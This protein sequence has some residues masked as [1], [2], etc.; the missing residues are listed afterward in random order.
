MSKSLGRGPL[1][2]LR[3]RVDADIRELI[4][5]NKNLRRARYTWA[6]RFLRN[7]IVARPAAVLLS[8]YCLA[9]IAIVLAA[10]IV[11]R[12]APW[13]NCYVAGADIS[14]DATGFFLSAQIGILAVLSVA[15]SVVT[16][17]TQKDDGSAVNTDVR[18]YYLESYSYGLASSG[19][20]LCAVLVVQLFWPLQPLVVF[21][22]GSEAVDSVK[23]SITIV[24]AA[25]LVLNLYLFLHFMGT[26]FR[27]VEPESRATLRKQYTANEIIPR[28]VRRRL[29]AAY[30]LAIP[31]QMFGGGDL[32]K[33]PLI[34]LGT[35][36]VS[37][38]KG[39][40][41]I[42]RAFKTPSRL[43]DIWLLPLGPALRGW[44][45]RTRKQAP[46]NQFGEEHWR[47]HL[48]VPTDFKIIQE[49]KF[50]F[51]LREGGAPLTRLERALIGVSFR[52]ARADQRED[53]LPTPTEFIE[54][55]VSKVV[56]QIESGAPNGFDNA[57]SE[58]VDFHSFV[59]AAQN[60]RDENGDLINLAQI[61]DGPFRQ[62]DFEWIREYRRAYT[63]ATN[64]M[65]SDGGFANGMSGLVARLWPRDA[66]DFPPAVL[67]NILELGRIQVS[68]FEGWVTKRAVI[69][70]PEGG[71]APDLAGSDL[72]AYD[73]AL[74][75]FVSAWEMLEQLIVSSFEVR[76][77]GSGDDAT[78]WQSA[79]ASWPSL[80]M[81]MRNAAFFVAAAVWNEDLA[82]SDRFRDM[83]V[84]WVQVFYA[85]L[86]HVYPF[87]DALMLTPDVLQVLWPDA[88]TATVRTLHYPQPPASAKTVFGLILREAHLDAIAITG[89]VLLHWFATKQ[90]PSPATAQCAILTL[91]REAQQG[92]GS[93]LLD[94]GGTVKSVFRL[95][96]DLL[97]RE[98]LRSPF[99]EGSYSAYLDGLIRLLNEM[100][101]P[102]MIPGR[103]YGG[104]V[105]D[106]F[107]T[108]TPE[109]LAILAGNL[110][111][112]GDEGVLDLIQRLLNNHPEFQVDR[113]LRD[114]EFQFG[115]YAAALDGEPDARFAATVECFVEKPDLLALRSRLKMIFDAVRSG[116]SEFRLSRICEAPLDDGRLQVVREAVQTALLADQRP[117]GAFQSITVDRTDR[118]L[119]LR[120]T[121]WGVL[122]RGVFTQPQMSGLTF[123]EIPALFVETTA[124]WVRNIGWYELARRPKRIER[125]DP[126][127]SVTAFLDLVREIGEDVALG[128]E[129]MLLVPYNRIG[130]PI[131]MTT[132]GFP[133]DDLDS[134]GLIREPGA[135]SGLGCS[136]AGTLDGIQIYTWRLNE[137]AVLCSRTLIRA[138]Y[139]G[140]VRA[141]DGFFDF[142]LFDTGDPMQSRIRIWLGVEFEWEERDHVEFKFGNP[143]DELADAEGGDDLQSRAVS[144]PIA[145]A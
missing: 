113:T 63:A 8:A 103:I 114:F 36:L 108:L 69:A 89:A 50:D 1:Q 37:D 143:P 86:Q 22:A 80:Q 111:A 116:I 3:A 2:S 71:Q 140:D 115:R 40:S 28:D 112:T 79:G 83:L 24:H 38:D 7:W 19:I 141:R 84:R 46:Q 48:A 41:E 101:T 128:D 72:H 118:K 104:F 54:Q 78:Y 121:D 107:Q 117:V 138:L 57:L 17:L 59:L 35:G 123:A 132:R 82:G 110:P 56:D 39:I 34:T 134:Y 131:S 43:I 12:F 93:T 55:L 67:I 10:W 14:K 25:W 70:T 13:L 106:G 102:R 81:H 65:T 88:Q 126:N 100:A 44:Q 87:R 49:E 105:L 98:A 42:S 119:E 52:F 16:L 66:I 74:I 129:L 96:F 32:S 145:A 77:S 31:Q 95:I 68:I 62:P 27:F 135:E 20:L 133:Q 75:Q 5:D 11:R 6:R 92:S 53:S 58:A 139:Y 21:I 30:Y 94:H 9:N 85:Q 61:N 97:A 130:E 33:G 29:L 51:L 125:L 144:G 136:Y 60:T 99:E 137:S 91:R 127:L 47:G 4:R 73:N 76:K 26:T 120:H 124:N 90:Q 15:I 122:D 18:L 45:Q 142:E 23:L 109:F 64:K